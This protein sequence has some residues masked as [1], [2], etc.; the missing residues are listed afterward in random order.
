M[1]VQPCPAC[2]QQMPRHL[3]SSITNDAADYYSCQ[4]CLHIWFIDRRDPSKVTHVTP[5]LKPKKDRR[6]T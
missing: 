1:A 4:A 3:E 6:G 5:F 2:G